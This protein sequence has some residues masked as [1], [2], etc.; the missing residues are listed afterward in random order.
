MLGFNQCEEC[1]NDHIALIIQF[2][3]AGIALVA[4]VIVLNL[5]VSVGTVNGLIFHANVVK[6]YEPIFFSGGPI[7]ILSQFISW[8]NLHLG[9]ETC[10]FDGMDSCSE[11]SLQFIFPAYIWFILIL[12]IILLRYSSK[13]VQLVGRQVI[14]VPATMILLSYTKPIRTVF[15]VIHRARIN[16]NNNIFLRWYIESNVQYV[17]GCHLPLFI[18]SLFVLIFLIVPYTFFLF[19]IPLFEGPLSKYMCCCQK[20]STYMKPFFDAYGGPYKDKCRF[21][22]GLLL[23]VRV[24]LALVVSQDVKATTSLAVLTCLLIV[25]IFMYFFLKGVYRQFSLVCLE[26]IFILNLIL[27]AYTN[28]QNFEKS[29]QQVPSIL[30]VSISFVLFC[31]I[32]FYHVRDRLLESHS[33]KLIPKVK[34]IFK[35]PPATSGTD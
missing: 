26:L 15:H 1:T 12:I 25:I 16:C 14:P 32:I 2:A 17:G 18:F 6:I 4:F 29:K 33:Q 23:L 24:I 27:M 22:T 9:I 7:P 10:F 5:T 31:G 28:L 30:L 8:I 3:V 20:L 11:T 13:V 21:W 35:K 34:N 19:T